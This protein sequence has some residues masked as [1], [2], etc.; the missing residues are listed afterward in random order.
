MENIENTNID[1]LYRAGLAHYAEALFAARH[2]ELLI[3]EAITDVFNEEYKNRLTAAL[4]SDLIGNGFLANSPNSSGKKLLEVQNTT[5][6]QWF[7]WVQHVHKIGKPDITLHIGYRY[8]KQQSYAVIAMMWMYAGIRDQL[9]QALT[10]YK[11][12][13]AEW[14]GLGIVIRSKPLALDGTQQD[15][16]AALQEVLDKFIQFLENKEKQTPNWLTTPV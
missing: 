15:F 1:S 11:Q 7:M 12:D 5:Q 9:L 10:T 3:D 14:D 13:F 8:Y 16:I 4:G 6:Q 2:F